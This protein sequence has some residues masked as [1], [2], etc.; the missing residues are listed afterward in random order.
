M[1]MMHA[2]GKTV[3]DPTFHEGSLSSHIQIGLSTKGR[4]VRV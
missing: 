2:L 4:V 3:N 1:E